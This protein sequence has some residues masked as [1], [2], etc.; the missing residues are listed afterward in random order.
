[1]SQR[2][3]VRRGQRHPQ[4]FPP[5]Y[6]MPRPPT[7]DDQ[8][9]RWTNK[10][11]ELSSFWIIGKNPVNGIPVSSGTEGALYYLCKY[12]SNGDATWCE[13]DTGFLDTITLNPDTGSSLTGNEFDIFGHV[14]G[15]AQVMET[16]TSGG[17]FLIENRVF[18]T[19][20]VV[21]PSS[22]AGERG[23]FTTIQGAIDAAVTD[24][25]ATNNLKK[26][27]IRSNTDPYIEDLTIP[28]GI[29]FESY[30]FRDEFNSSVQPVRIHGAHTLADVCNIG[31][32]G[33]KWTNSTGDI[34]TGGAT[35]AIINFFDSNVNVTGNN[36][37]V[38]SAAT[39]TFIYA[40]TSIFTANTTAIGFDISSGSVL[41]DD[42]TFG[43]CYFEMD[44][45][46]RFENC[47]SVGNVSG[48]T[49]V[50]VYAINTS[51]SGIIDADIITNSG[52]ASEFW[53]CIFGGNF[54]A[55]Y[56]FSGNPTVSMV[57]CSMPSGLSTPRDF[58][59][60]S[61]QVLTG[62]TLVGNV[63]KAERSASNVVAGGGENYIGITDTSSPRT[64]QIR[65]GDGGSNT[66]IDYQIFVVDE[67]GNAGTNNIT[68]TGVDS[69]N[70]NGSSSYVIDQDYGFALFHTDGT[71]WYVISDSKTGGGSGDVVG[72]AS[73][74]D[75]AVARFDGVTGKLIQDSG[76]IV[77]DSDNIS[78]GTWQG[79]AVDEV[80]GG[81]AQTTYATG[82]ILYA[83]A[84]NTLSK[85][86]AGSNGEVLTLAAGVP[87]WDSVNL[88][89]EVFY[90]KA[91]DFDALETN[92]AP[93]V[94]DTGSNA[95]ILARAFD[96]TTEEFVNFSLK[97]PRNINTSGTVTFRVW[98]YAATAAA[99]RNVALT[100][101]HRP[102]DNSES[103]DQT[104]T[105]EDSGDIAIDATQDD[106]TEATWTETVAN[107]GWSANDI[108]LCRLSRPNATSNDLVGDLN[109]IGF[110]V[111]IPRSS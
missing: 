48:K 38:S 59:D 36:Q 75:N 28:A 10:R 35:L 97:V 92:F 64:V 83:S 8:I 93:L 67:S 57:N 100:F 76:V 80:Y 29:V 22:T 74:T 19:P 56:C 105:S 101:D 26:I 84:A 99:S 30:G 42:C 12:E 32:I 16:I 41:F 45:E 23:T 106:I 72:P 7:T 15:S 13:I 89:D 3:N 14:S 86:V 69:E 54:A 60:S 88:P 111:E 68:I 21:D 81:T 62:Q 78:G 49:E 102:L 5:V 18:D 2:N 52:T 9:D 87:S 90:Y 61:I 43:D 103:W 94:Q 82:D 77:D 73:S 108:V 53:N 58:A 31:S 104:Y 25:V 65:M 1:M 51:F 91:S 44:G 39:S 107:L 109:V 27:K 96:D 24:G 98:M 66:L 50:N 95:K 55:R 20:Y 110:S 47:K 6:Y 17:D 70:I 46:A 34:F 85:L 63:L 79:N 4:S 33:I 37:I 40:R 71:E 11:Y